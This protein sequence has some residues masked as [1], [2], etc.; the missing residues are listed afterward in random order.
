M[1]KNDHAMLHIMYHTL[2]VMQF[3]VVELRSTFFSRDSN[4]ASMSILS[5]SEASARYARKNDTE[6]IAGRMHNGR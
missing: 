6:T 5:A 2:E 1:G 3:G 4:S